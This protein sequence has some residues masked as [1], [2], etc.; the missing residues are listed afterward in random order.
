MSD[1]SLA[2]SKEASN[3]KSLLSFPNS[4]LEDSVMKDFS[5]SSRYKKQFGI[6]TLDVKLLEFLNNLVIYRESK[7]KIFVVQTC[8]KSNTYGLSCIVTVSA[9]LPGS[10]D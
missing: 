10:S 7:M 9:S 4:V 2:P 6:Y 8:G 1:L 5:I 3:W